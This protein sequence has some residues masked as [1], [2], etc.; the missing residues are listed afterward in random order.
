MSAK[1]CTTPAAVYYRMSTD[2]QAGSIKRQREQA[3]PYAARQGYRVVAEYT[4]EGIAGDEFDKRHGLQRLLADAK[5]GR[6]AVVVCD[7]PSRLARMGYNQFAAL[8][9]YPLEKAGVILDSVSKGRV[10]WDDLGKS[11]CN[12]ID[13][14]N[15]REESVKISRRVMGEFLK[16]ERAGSYLGGPV[17]YGF[18][19]VTEMRT[20]RGRQVE[21]GV[22]L[23]V[24]PE[25]VPAVRLIFELAADHHTLAEIRRQLHA[26]GVANPSGGPLWSR[27]TLLKLIKNP[28][29][30]GDRAW[31]KQSSGKYHRQAAGQ[32]RPRAAGEKDHATNAPADWLVTPDTHE[33]IIDRALFV[34]A[35]E[36]VRGNKTRTCPKP[37]A[38]FL[39]TGLLACPCGASMLGFTDRGRRAYCCSRYLSYGKSAC[40]KNT[41]NEAAMTRLILETLRRTFLSPEALEALRNRV[42]RLVEE[43]RDEKRLSTLRGQLATL[44]GKIRPALEKLLTLDGPTLTEAQALV[45]GWV[46][47]RDALREELRRADRTDAVDN[48]EAVIKAAEEQLWGL[49]D[50]IERADAGHLRS[51][52]REWVHKVNLTFEHTTGPSGRVA[53]QLTGGEIALRPQTGLPQTG[54]LV[55]G[56]KAQFLSSAATGWAVLALLE[57]IPPRESSIAV[58]R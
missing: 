25:R 54:L 10:Q 37:G 3:L 12:F 33:A 17:P 50:A 38:G 55:P 27:N 51:V 30:V 46:R 53:C 58:R 8:I 29:Y 41:V 5:A 9:A 45:D 42:R 36:A 52:L 24:L 14:H 35:N 26:R 2:D 34:K 16:A 7:E 40:H 48:L 13:A 28:A 1:D 11:L 15:S 39:L 6:F 44:E 56:G 43:R 20:V 18:R 4:D 21:R 32:M 47:E 49:E 23:A 22:G 31:G 19:L 57:T